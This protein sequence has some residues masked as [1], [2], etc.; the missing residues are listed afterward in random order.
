MKKLTLILA[1]GLLPLFTGSGSLPKPSEK[2]VPCIKKAETIKV[3]VIPPIS[4]SYY[5][6]LAYLESRGNYRVINQYG[7]VGKYQF[8]KRTL[9]YLQRKGTLQIT[10]YEIENFIDFPEA[11]ERAVRALTKGNLKI[12]RSYGLHNH[13]GSHIKGV[14]ITMEG[15]L[16][17]AHLLGAYAVKQFIL[18]KGEIIKKDGKNTTIITYME[19]FVV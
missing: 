11:Q 18:S 2:E 3:A 10:D 17:S 4:Q 14:E 19:A 12:L 16:A 9:K 13:V 8:S 5:D 15:M 7:Y 1:V 6:K